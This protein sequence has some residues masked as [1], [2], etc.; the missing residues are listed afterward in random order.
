ME[1][2]NLFEEKEQI[3]DSEKIEKKKKKEKSKIAVIVLLSCILTFIATSFL[4]SIYHKNPIIMSITSDGYS[5]VSREVMAYIDNVFLYD[6]D[7]E[8]MAYGACKGMVEALGDEYT[9]YLPPEE[10]EEFMNDGAGD[11]IGIG[12]VFSV[13]EQNEIFVVGT[14]PDT[15]GSR[16]G[17]KSGDVLETVDSTPCTIDNYEEMIDY[18][19]GEHISIYE[20]ENT[21]VEFEYSRKDVNGKKETNKVVLNREKIHVNSVSSEMKDDKIGYIAVD[22][23]NKSTHT[24]FCEAYDKLVSEGMEELII[25]LRDNGGGDF[26]VAVEMAGYF[27]EDESLVVYTIDKN[28]KKVEHFSQKKKYD[29]KPVILINSRTASA[30]EVFCAAMKDYGAAKEIVGEKKLW[31]RNYSKCISD[32]QRRWAY[33]YC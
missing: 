18:I 3:E 6:V 22:S 9:R 21:S 27:L 23:F 12:V 28:N 8:K 11:Y 24:E 5:D 15:P 4:S 30:S 19:R 33:S 25:D 14:Y 1:G 13:N 29:I 32:E 16:A 26:E 7:E 31:K 10:F 17:L 2:N 20:R